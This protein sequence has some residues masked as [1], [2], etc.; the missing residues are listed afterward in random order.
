M[1]RFLFFISICLSL[2]ACDP[3]RVYEE[4][5][6]ISDYSWK[7]NEPV[8]FDFEITDTIS[9][10]N[11]F[12]NVRHSGDYG[13]RNLFLFVKTSFPNGKFKHDTVE[14]T[15]ADINGWKGD[16]LGDLWD[17]Q[18]PFQLRKKFPLKGKYSI[19]Y[20]QAMYVDPLPGIIDVGL[21]IERAEDPE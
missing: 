21:R 15:L 6:G 4:N 11:F 20:R 3:N 1:M 9:L 19:E 12:I 8:K 14:V 16:G 17:L 7:S 2:I 5:E 10:H 18:V 13:F